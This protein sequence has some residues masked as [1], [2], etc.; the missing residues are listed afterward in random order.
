V[1]GEVPCM[2]LLGSMMHEHICIR[3][4]GMPNYGRYSVHCAIECTGNADTQGNK[5]APPP[6]TVEWSVLAGTGAN[7]ASKLARLAYVQ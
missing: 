3:Q 4:A 5:R 2:Q 1:E 7:L 6:R